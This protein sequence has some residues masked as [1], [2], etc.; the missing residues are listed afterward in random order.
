VDHCL[1][2]SEYTIPRF[3]VN[4]DSCFSWD[5]MIDSCALQLSHDLIQHH[6][7]F[8]HDISHKN[9][10]DEKKEVCPS[11]EIS[12]PGELKPS[13]NEQPSGV[14]SRENLTQ[15]APGSS[16]QESAP[17]VKNKEENVQKIDFEDP[18]QRN[19]SNRIVRG[20]ESLAILSFGIQILQHPQF[21]K[22][23]WVTSK[24]REGP[25]TDVN[26]PWKGWPF[27]SCLLHSSTSTDS[28]KP[29]NVVKGKE[30]SLYVRGLVA[31]GLLAYRCFYS[32]VM[33]VCS[34]VRKVL[35]LLVGQI[36]T[37][38][39][40]KRNRFQHFHIL[41]QVAY[42]DDIVNSWAYTFQR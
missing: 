7:Q 14:A 22:L 41:S 19:P 3:S 36:R 27:N 17:N 2:S 26:G 28:N 13:E 32:S 34:E 15:V 4:I 37:K 12:A 6:V 18:I 20:S 5:E 33:E 8:L 38:I 42:L 9:N 30:K 16:Q 31:V 23:C 40:E 39:L 21:S 10:H 29:G 1:A 24:L 35:E 25:C 11:M